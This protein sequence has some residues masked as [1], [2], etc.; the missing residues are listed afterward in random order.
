MLRSFGKV[1]GLAGV[2]LGFALA[3]VARAQEIRAALG[4]WAVSGAAI[5]IGRGALSDNAWLAETKGRLGEDVR[6]LDAVLAQAGFELVGG[7]LLFR[8]VRHPDAARRF[9]RLCS[10]GILTRPFA[11]ASEWLRFG[12]PGADDR[13]RLREALLGLNSGAGRR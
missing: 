9:E 4:P 3:D 13:A 2:R 5:E 8:L 7:T 10:A 6:W 1:Y 11:A 12:I